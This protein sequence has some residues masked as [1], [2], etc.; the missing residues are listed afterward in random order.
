M[1][2]PAIQTRVGSRVFNK[3]RGA[4]FNF[5]FSRNFLFF[6]CSFRCGHACAH[7]YTFAQTQW[8]LQ[9]RRDAVKAKK[10]LPSQ[11]RDQ[12]DKSISRSEQLV[13]DKTNTH[14]IWAMKN[15]L[16][17]LGR[18]LC[19]P[20]VVILC[21]RVFARA[22]RFCTQLMCSGCFFEYSRRGVSSLL[23]ASQ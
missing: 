23:F 1:L 12:F 20:L 6:S 18:L 14:R 4:I 17:S 13:N 10:H 22:H 16:L 8:Q 7:K 5:V 15:F 11:W 9:H 3:R 21:A 19:L 2:G